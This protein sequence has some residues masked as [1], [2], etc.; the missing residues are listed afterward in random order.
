MNDIFRLLKVNFLGQSP[1]WYK[2]TILVFLIINPFVYHFVSPFVAGWLVLLEFIFTLACALKCYPLQP[3]GLLAIESI[4]IGLTNAHTVYDEVLVNIPTL[5]LLIFMVA[6][7]FFIKDVLFIAMTKLFLAIRRKYVLSLVFCLICAS[8]SA[9]LD[10]LTLVSIAIAVCFNFYAIYH[11]VEGH[12]GNEKEIKEFRG[13]LRNLIMHGTVGTII[14]GAMTMVG[15]P[16]NIMIGSKMG[17]SFTGF[18]AHCSVVSVPAALAGFTVCFCLEYFKFPG[19]QYQMPDRARE[20]IL[21]DYNKKIHEMTEHN[22]YVYAVQIVSFVLLVLALAFHV[23]EVG[24]IGI[25]LIVIVTAFT[26]LTKEHDLGGA[27]TNAMPFTLLIVVFFA[28]LGVVHEQHLVAPLA[29]WVFTFSGKSRLI[30]LYFTNGT[31]SF[32]SDNVFIATI[33]ITEVENAYAGGVITQMLAGLETAF[34]GGTF[35]QF[36]SQAEQEY[37]NNKAITDFLGEARSAYLNESLHDFIAGAQLQYAD[38]AIIS[39]EEYE[40]LAVT[41]NMGTNIPA[42]ATPNGHAAL[43]FLLASPLA[44]LLHL[45]YF[46]MLKLALP[47]TIAMSLVGALAIYFCL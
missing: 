29:E 8:L 42:M 3:G 12:S 27:F 33:F 46:R 14:G 43:L 30:A 28:I 13:F 32:V 26:G 15:E 39:K 22:I 6:A 10:A 31:L 17:W 34:D 16:Q 21:K 18:I 44:P 5:L 7:I 9:F 1:T 24:L 23:A 20:L 38:K 47:Y 11:R 41:V 4:V 45:S 40:Q 36:L 37:A 19:F 2:I 25:G 35:V